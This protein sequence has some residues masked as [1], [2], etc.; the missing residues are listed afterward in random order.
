MI[1]RRAACVQLLLEST[2]RWKALICGAFVLAVLGTK[3]WIISRFGNPTP[4]N[5]EWDAQVA[6]LFIP[7]FDSISRPWSCN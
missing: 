5:D 3:L 1:F 4:L 2:S 6:N 7:Y